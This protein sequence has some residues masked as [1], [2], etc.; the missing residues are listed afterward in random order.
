[1]AE[2]VEYSMAEDTEYSMTEDM[3]YSTAEDSIAPA[4]AAAG[5]ARALSAVH[6]NGSAE[7]LCSL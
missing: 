7:T 2:D 1:M 3:E 4:S 5:G 6:S